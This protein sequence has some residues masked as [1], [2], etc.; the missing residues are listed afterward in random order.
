[1]HLFRVSCPPELFPSLFSETLNPRSLDGNV[2]FLDCTAGVL[3]VL[4]TL[5]SL[6]HFR[7]RKCSIS[8]NP[9]TFGRGFPYIFPTALHPNF[10]LSAKRPSYASKHNCVCVVSREIATAEWFFTSLA[11]VLP[12]VL[13]QR[14]LQLR[15]L[16]DGAEHDDLQRL[17][18][19]TVLQHVSVYSTRLVQTHPNTNRAGGPTL[20]TQTP[21]DLRLITCVC[22]RTSCSSH[23]FIQVWVGKH[24][25]DWYVTCYR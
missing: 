7:H 11:L 10:R 18:K 9:I 23:A 6:F 12:S 1:M 22:G 20:W 5:S 19:E 14:L 3:R 25:R 21:A 24:K 8:W 13:A 16:Q 17:W 15:G 2:I 4:D